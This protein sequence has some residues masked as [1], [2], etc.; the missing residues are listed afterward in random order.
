M[1][2]TN[3]P[4]ALDAM[5][6]DHAPQETV[7]GAVEYSRETG[8]H[9]LLVGREEPLRSTLDGLGVGRD[10]TRLQI[11]PAAEVIDFGEG[12]KSIRLKR[13]S[14]IHV[15]ARLVK[16]EKANAFVSAGHT[17][18]VM[19]VC[20]T[21]FGLLDGVDRPALPAPV[22]K[23][24]GGFN[25]L[26]DAGANV[27]CRAEHFRQF[28]VMGYHYARRIFGVETPRV[29]L[30]SIGEEDAKGNQMLKEVSST[31]RETHINFVGNIEGNH[32]LHDGADVIVCDGFVG[33]VA[34]KVA[35]GTVEAIVSMLKEEIARNP[36]RQLM[37]LGLSPALRGVLRKADYAEYGG[38]P[39]LGLRQVAIVAHG[40]S[41]AKA[42]RNALRAGDTCAASPL[43]AR[44]AEDIAALHV[45]EQRLAGS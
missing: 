13:N 33:N 8:R 31:L 16:H 17:G 29:A 20:K 19:A 39:L 23:L 24:G 36:V 25:V 37:A 4:I 14:S 35:E 2:D 44:I 40:R 6:G 21:V 43:L 12:I 7:R 11:E 34:L 27:D 42:I 38:V 30:L 22:P 15:A 10:D 26:L 32:L 18:A 28:A 41:P 9:V 5:G 1:S 45:A 3:L